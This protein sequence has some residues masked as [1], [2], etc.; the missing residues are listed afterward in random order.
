MK[1]F[2]KSLV[3]NLEK[4]QNL[5]DRIINKLQMNDIFIFV[6]QA[7]LS[8][9][10]FRAEVIDK[11]IPFNFSYPIPNDYINPIEN[12]LIYSLKPEY[13]ERLINKYLY[14]GKELII[15]NRIRAIQIYD[16]YM[17]EF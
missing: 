2:I 15:S 14:S 5:L 16:I 10:P 3:D 12:A 8:K 7:M 6:G 11:L 1:L 13:N 9:R 4:N 17:C